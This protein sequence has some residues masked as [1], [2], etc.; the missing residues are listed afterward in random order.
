MGDAGVR[1]YH[2]FSTCFLIFKMGELNFIVLNV[3]F[4]L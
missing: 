1:T 3:I 2:D 4:S